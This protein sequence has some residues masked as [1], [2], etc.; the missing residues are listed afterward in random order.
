HS[1]ALDYELV[2]HALLES[3][4]HKVFLIGSK[5]KRKN[6]ENRLKKNGFDDDAFKKLY[7]PIGLYPFKTRTPAAIAAVSAAHLLLEKEYLIADLKKIYH[8]TQKISI[9]DM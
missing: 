2:A 5:T 1:H 8:N 4:Y 6:F 9:N 7:C 3:N